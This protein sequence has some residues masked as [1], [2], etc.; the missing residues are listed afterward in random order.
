MALGCLDRIVGIDQNI[1][2]NN[3]AFHNKFSK[4]QIICAREGIVI[5]YEKLIKLRPQALL[6]SSK[7]SWEDAEE[8]LKYFGINVIV[9]D[10]HDLEQF[11]NNRKNI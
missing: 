6:I 5:D 10:T 1:L 9:I 11:S 4:E 7:G 2:S 3:K 8:K